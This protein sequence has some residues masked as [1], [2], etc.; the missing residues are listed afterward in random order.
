MKKKVI[1]DLWKL[2][3]KYW[4]SYINNYIADLPIKYGVIKFNKSGCEYLYYILNLY[5][6]N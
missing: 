1:Y 5:V 3:K 2:T 6:F 4:N